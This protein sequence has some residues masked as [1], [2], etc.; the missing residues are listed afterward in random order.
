MP[1]R[2]CVRRFARAAAL[3]LGL[4]APSCSKTEPIDA[5]PP[6]L[7]VVCVVDQLRADFLERFGARLAAQKG[8]GFL[9][10]AR[11]GAN[12]A[13][14][15]HRHGGTFTGPG[16]ASIASG[17]YPSAHGIVGNQWLVRGRAKPEYCVADERAS[18][19]GAPDVTGA[20][21]VSVK[22][23]RGETLGDAMKLGLTPRSR[24]IAVSLK[25]RSAILMGGAAPTPR[26]GSTRRSAD[27]SRTRATRPF[28]PART[29]RRSGGPSSRG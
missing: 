27:S 5:R 3:T 2:P 24:V 12:Y 15:R 9:R 26:S 18:I 6:R 10:L 17:A 28:P 23:L 16:H 20:E 8:E 21:K 29:G 4:V 14:C 25:D 22:N 13:D 7:V 11:K 1:I 19:F